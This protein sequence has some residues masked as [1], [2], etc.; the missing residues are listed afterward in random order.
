MKKKSIILALIAAAVVLGAFTGAAAAFGE[1]YT[2]YVQSVPSGATV[3]CNIAENQDTTPGY[4]TIMDG[5][6]GIP[7]SFS[8]RFTKD[9]YEPYYYTVYKSDFYNNEQTIT[10]HLTPIQEDGVLY[11]TS[12]PKGA[13]VY[14]DN[15]YYGT[16]PVSDEISPG[17]HTVRISLSG[18]STVSKSVYVGE[19]STATVSVSL[20]PVVSTGY[21]SVSS[22]PKYADVYVD[23]AYMGQTPMTMSLD[24]GTHSVT[25]KKSGYSN[26]STSV[27]INAGQTSSLSAVLAETE[28]G[29]YV[30][31]ASNPTGAS[32][33]ID[34]TYVGNTPASSSAGTTSY[35]SAGPY[36][37]NTYHTLVLKLDGYNTYSTS[38]MPQEKSVITITPTLTRSEPTTAN[39]HVTSSP[40]GASVYVDN[41]YYGTTPAT[42]PNLQVGSHSVKVSALGYTDSVNTITVSAGQS[43]EL[44]VTLVPTSPTP[45]ASPAP[46][47][48]ILAGL[49]AAGIFFAARRH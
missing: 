16:T 18:Y 43:V 1:S 5:S 2:L 20:D 12:S 19:G 24:T 17:T 38:F 26:Y 48:G 41:V 36:S 49:A 44:P 15:V 33:Y 10:A 7:G 37:T 4:L 13:S 42:I 47:L 45:G 9:G 28:T 30:S 11:V 29:G 25:F 8:V 21:L 6:G 27:R 14:V 40:A 39:L 32:V 22:T 46:I 23:N 34:G 31:I 35:L 3:I